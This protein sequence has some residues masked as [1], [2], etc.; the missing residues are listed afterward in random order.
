MFQSIYTI[1]FTVIIL[2]VMITSFILKK[3]PYQLS[4]KAI[5]T[6]FTDKKMVFHFTA[7]FLI[8]YFNK[9]EQKIGETLLSEDYT[10]FIHDFEGNL[11]Y[12]IQHFTTNDIFNFIL[13]FFYIIGFPTLMISSM[14]IYLNIDDKRSFY[15]FVY[16]LM[17]NYAI[18][19]PFFL[20]FPVYEVWYYDPHVHF[21]IPDIY[22]S[23]EQEYRPLSGINNNFPSLHT[24]ISITT[25]LIALRSNS[26]VFARLAFFIAIVIVF[27]TLYLG[28]HWLSDMTAGILLAVLAS[29]T[30][31]RISEH[32]VQENRLYANNRLR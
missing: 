5:Y 9:I 12:L 24:A 8:L 1:T 29:Q 13:T 23:F 32:I 17:I 20:F 26:K 21:L 18:A 27:S 4:K 15:S 28:I 6:L 11:V 22:P 30:G 25:S 16:A 7:L 19:I 14:L 3:D 31:L 2:S 10:H